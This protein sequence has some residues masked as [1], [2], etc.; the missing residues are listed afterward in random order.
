MSEDTT[1]SFYEYLLHSH[2]YPSDLE[3]ILKE[4]EE[5]IDQIIKLT[6]EFVKEFLHES[7]TSLPPQK[8]KRLQMLQSVVKND[9]IT[10]RVIGHVHSIFSE[11]NG[12][13]RQGLL[14]PTTRAYIEFEKWVIP[15]VAV[16][17]IEEYSHLIILFKFHLNKNHAYHPLVHPPKRGKKT[18]VFTTRSP[19]RPNNIGLTVSLIDKFE[20]NK[21]YLKGIDLVEGT[22]IIDIKPYIFADS[23][24]IE[25]IKQPEWLC[26]SSHAEKINVEIDEKVIPK[27]KE[28]I[29]KLEFYKSIEEYIEVIKEVLSLDIRSV[30][31]QSKHEIKRYG[32]L[33]DKTNIIFCYEEKGI[34][35]IDIEYIE[36]PGKYSKIKK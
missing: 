18:S 23:I 31:M 30:H 6:E 8:P 17:G 24:P 26:R 3:T 5:I 9:Y 14:S 34:R 7:I 32:V 13:P 12:T 16:K 20:N 28:L 4:S 29:N 10:Y 36:C 35:V 21:L 11:L 2:G 22:P 1:Y 27:M 15:E 25:Q 33:I 19:H